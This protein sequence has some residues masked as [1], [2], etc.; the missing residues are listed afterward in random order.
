MEIPGKREKFHRLRALYRLRP[1]YFLPGFELSFFDLLSDSLIWVTIRPGIRKGKQMQCGFP[2]WFVVLLLIPAICPDIA[3]SQAMRGEG[4]VAPAPAIP[5]AS[6]VPILSSATSQEVLQGPILSKTTPPTAIPQVRPI[7]DRSVPINL[8]TALRLADARPLL[9]AAA[10]ARVQIAMAQLQ[11]AQVLWLPNINVGV[12]YLTHGGG[13][14]NNNGTLTSQGTNQFFGGGSLE[15]RFAMTDAIFAPLAAQQELNARRSDV[16]TARNNVLLQTAEAY[17]TLQQ[18]RGNYAAMTDAVEKGRLLVKRVESL[19]KS[20]TSGDE[21]YRS[22]TLVASLEQAQVSALQQWRVASAN[23]TRVLRLNPTLLVAPLEPDHLQVTLIDPTQAI[24]DLIPIGLTNRPEL[25]SHQAQIQATLVRLKQEKLRPLMP[26]ILITGNGT[27]DFLYQGSIFGAGTGS[28]LN[29]WAGRADVSVQAVWTLSNLGFG[30]H[31]R[32]NERKGEVELATVE[33]Y[34]VQDQVASEVAQAKADLESAAER[35]KMAEQGL[36]TSVETYQGN[37][38]GMGQ[39]TRLGD[40]LIL[41][42]R[43]QEVVAALAQL[44]QAYTNYFNTVA[45]YNRSQFRLFHAMGYPAEVLACERPPGIPQPVDT[46][47]PGYLP[48]VVAPEPCSSCPQR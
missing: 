16:Q 48:P 21:I 1:I 8:A 40:V 26:S 27:P 47:R 22:R 41:V 33:L 6:Q 17:F 28:S 11:K 18:A 38:K 36:K 9:I 34:Q 12:D 32:V 2:R 35:V 43:P 23:L 46:S 31:A 44:Q 25:A 15:V 29:Q 3:F 39:T 45:D 5:N 42:N 10:Q 7:T 13:I 37:L 30:Y 19:A 14:E 4:V 20:L 24:D